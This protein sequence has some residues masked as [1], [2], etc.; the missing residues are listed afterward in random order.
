MESAQRET[1]PSGGSLALLTCRAYCRAT[2]ESTSTREILT[3]TTRSSG[4]A[5]SVDEDEASIA[6]RVEHLLDVGADIDAKGA[7]E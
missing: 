5:L 6:S 1:I 4:S 2:R 7:M 3:A